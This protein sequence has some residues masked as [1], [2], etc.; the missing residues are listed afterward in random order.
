MRLGD[1]ASGKP[2]EQWREAV[3]RSWE[4]EDKF[5]RRF[6]RAAYHEALR[7]A[8]KLKRNGKGPRG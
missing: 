2:A 6:A 4:L 3:E 1:V 8:F 7:V 5:G